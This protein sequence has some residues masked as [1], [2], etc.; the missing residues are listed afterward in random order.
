MEIEIGTLWRQQMASG[1]E[2][3]ALFRV[4]WGMRNYRWGKSSDLDGVRAFPTR[5][6]FIGPL[7][8]RESQ[9]EGW[10][11]HLNIN[12]FLFPPFS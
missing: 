11:A 1:I 9:W 12:S 5:D 3:G 6:I 10:R 4:R 8:V 7:P 2:H